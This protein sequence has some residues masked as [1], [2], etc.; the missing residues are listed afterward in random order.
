MVKK[1]DPEAVK[2]EQREKAALEKL[3]KENVKKSKENE[4][5]AK[6]IQQEI[7]AQQKQFEAA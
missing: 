6:A 7:D 4:S 2:R 1:T 3:L 5:L